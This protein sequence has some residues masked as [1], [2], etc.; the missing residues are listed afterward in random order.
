MVYSGTDD[1]FQHG[2][3]T[4][5]T[6]KTVHEWL[7]EHHGTSQA[8]NSPNLNRME[9]VWDYLDHVV[10]SLDRSPLTLQHLSA[11]LESS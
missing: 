11:E 1:I 4:Y 8:P 2:N 3:A 6:P 7:K 9:N 5:Q 10:R